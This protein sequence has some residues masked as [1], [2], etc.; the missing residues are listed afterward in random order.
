MVLSYVKTPE[1]M[2]PLFEKAEEYVQGYFSQENRDPTKGTIT[3]NGQRYI[4]VRAQSM[5]VEFLEF[6]KAKYPGFTEEDAFEAAA[7]LLYDMAKAMGKADANN[8]HSAMQVTDPIAKLSSGPV[9]FAFTGW[10]FVDVFPESKPSP[11]EDYYL[12]Y[13]H[14]QS[15]EADSWLE[16]ERKTSQPVCFMN[17]GYSSGWCE[18]SFGVDLVSKEIMCRGM[19][20]D[21][22]RFIMA[23]PNKIDEYIGTYKNSHPDLFGSENG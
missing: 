5:S 19:G 20:S 17:A 6:V 21:R 1:E 3:I 2:Q 8:F 13:D 15:F 4:L 22:C 11:D 9:H 18:E 10:A 7:K 14:P 16:S 23:H 12:I